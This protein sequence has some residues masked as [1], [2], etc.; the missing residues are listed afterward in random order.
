MC[1]PSF[2][3][4]GIMKT[5]LVVDIGTSSMRGILFNDQFEELDKI[6]IKSLPLYQG[7]KVEQDVSSWDLGL[8]DILH[9]TSEYMQR[10]GTRLFG[11]FVTS[12]RSSLI[13]LDK[14]GKALMPAIMWQ[15]KRTNSIVEEFKDYENL[16]ISRTGAKLNPVYLGPKIYYV[17]K[18]YP[19]VYEKTYKFLSIADYLRFKLT[20]KLIT[21]YSYAS[22]TSL[23]NLSQRK[24]DADILALLGIEDDKLCRIEPVGVIGHYLSKDVADKYGLE[25]ETPFISAGGDQQCSA[26]GMGVTDEGSL[27]LTLGSGGFL[28][29]PTHKQIDTSKMIL[30]YHSV[31]N[32]Y[33]AE[34]L[35]ISVASLL[36]YF[37]RTF[38]REMENETFYQLISDIIE[39][40]LETNTIHLPHYQGRGTPDWNNDAKGAYFNLTFGTTKE[41]MLLAVVE[42]IGIEI[43]NNINSFETLLDTE[44]K[45][46]FV[47]GGIANNKQILQLFS[48]IIGIDLLRPVYAE[49]TALGALII[50]VNALEENFEI[51]DF[52]KRF[53]LRYPPEIFKVNHTKT[54]YYEEKINKWNKLYNK[55]YS[56]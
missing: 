18:M 41:E 35:L 12:Q 55:L 27:S 32:R 56:K 8:D 38:Y 47:A 42:S 17:K 34:G 40:D 33:L 13:C 16:F 1:G 31:D 15:D 10:N 14:N 19:D 48:N 5:Y 46:I 11:V 49:T 6:T 23:F 7:D 54:K 20:G 50:G 24:W 45:Q 29:M 37:H 26:V 30:N 36:N 43:K 53:T 39:G 52:N 28:L 44:I 4:R 3:R 21:D 25:N 9:F 22:R 51:N 2:T